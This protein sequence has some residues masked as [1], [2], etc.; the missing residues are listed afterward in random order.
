MKN[1]FDKTVSSEIINRIEQLTSDTAPKWGKMNVAQMLAHC[2][3]PYEYIFEKK[4]TKP[5]M[6][7]AFML[8]IFVK[9]IVV[10]EKPYKTNS[11]TAPDFIIS[12]ERVF[13]EEKERLINYI[14]TTQ[15][16]GAYFF[17][18]KE[19]HSFG[20][21]STQEWNNMFYKHLDHHLRQF[22]V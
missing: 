10:S 22:S 1:I 9:N 7:K 17:N 18:H 20:P 14:K 21:L 6:L 2:S 15:E 19:S 11:R 4:H 13:A 16:L 3:I 5:N 8:K 12:D